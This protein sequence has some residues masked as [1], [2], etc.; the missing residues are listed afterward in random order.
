MAK[1][2]VFIH[3]EKETINLRRIDKTKKLKIINEE[4]KQ[5]VGL[6]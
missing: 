2:A 4:S 1:Q 5:S 6:K 3:I